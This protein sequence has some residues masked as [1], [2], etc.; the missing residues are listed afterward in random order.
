MNFPEFKI[1]KK[2]KAASEEIMPQIMPVF[3]EIDKITEY[4][5]QKVLASFKKFNVSEQHFNPTT[6]YGYNDRGR[7]ILD[8]VF[9]HAFE[10]EDALVRHTIASGTHALT[11]ALFGVLRPGDIMLS[12]TGLPYDTIH[13]V[14][15]IKDSKK[16]SLKDFG[17]SYKQIDL[18]GT[19]KINITAIK[20][21]ISKNNKIKLVYIQKSRGYTLRPSLKNKEIS[22][23]VKEVKNTNK[24]IIIM[25]DNCYG[26]FTELHEPS[27]YGADLLAGS[28]IKNPGGAIAPCGGY[29]AGRYDLIEKCSYRM[30]T[31]GTGREIGA[32]LNANRE[33]YMGFYNAPLVVGEAMKTAVFAAAMAK[34]FGFCAWPSEFEER[35]D[36]IQAIGLKT[37]ENLIRFCKGI[38]AGSPI[39]SYVIPEPSPMPGYESKVIMAAGAFTGG[40][41]IELSADAP[42]RE[43]Y[44][45]WLQGGTNF[46]TAKIG[47]LQAFSELI[48]EQNE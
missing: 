37:S 41:S 42:L 31:P 13:E 9:A 33:L 7:D 19:G 1:N 36:I 3:E 2:I 46:Y 23:I 21:H 26:E 25:V 28:L 44:A 8:K 32:T 12:V 30:T 18:T 39:D 10:C 27:Y 5:S 43:P 45:V 20:E 6:G 24:D 4:N 11:I 47:I 40:S 14:I 17:I 34:E 48:A 15:G 22:E 35:G 16:G 38:Q 29:I